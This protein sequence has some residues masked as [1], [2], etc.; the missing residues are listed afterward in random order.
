MTDEEIYNLFSHRIVE[1]SRQYFIG[2]AERGDQKTAYVAQYDVEKFYPA[3]KRT[4]DLIIEAMNSLAQMITEMNFADIL[5]AILD[6]VNAHEDAT[7]A[8]K[9]KPRKPPTYDR[10]NIKLRIGATQPPVKQF[11][12]HPRNREYRKRGEPR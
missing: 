9:R 8:E 12:R 4:V 3:L 2:L 10:H 7:P 5:Q 1:A 11:Y 6:Y